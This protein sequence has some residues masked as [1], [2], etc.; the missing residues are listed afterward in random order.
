VRGWRRRVAWIVVAVA[1]LVVAARA[2]LDPLAAWRTRRILA[3]LDGMRSTF[4]RVEVSVGDLGYTIHD[5]RIEKL[6]AGGARTPFFEV[7]R[8]HFGLDWNELLHRH[9]VASVDLLRP[10]LN[11]VQAGKTRKPSETK[12]RIEGQQIEET[13]KIGRKLESLA[14]FLL[15]RL[16][17]REGEVRWIDAREPERPQLGLHGLE[18][19]IENFATRPAL[20]KGEPTVLAARATLQR[21]GRVSLFATLDPLAK[22]LTFAGQ[23]RLEG[24]R[25]VELRELMAAK[26]DIAPERGTM[27]M[28][29]RFRAVDGK[30]S[31]GL[32][33]FVKGAS[34]EPA[35][36]GVVP[37]LKSWLAD[38][39]LHIFSDDVPGRNAL[40][41]TIPLE[42]RVDHP[43]AQGIPTILGI[44]RNAFVR[45]LSDSM[46]GLPP[47]KAKQPQGALEQARHALKPKR[48]EP[49][50]QPEGDRK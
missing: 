47:P 23:A 31:G 37:R 24:L 30:L 46:T 45:G 27:D 50:A 10:K 4:S 9:V 1:V 40:A 29:L 38:E 41:T 36:P 17:V 25:L 7:E 16:Q 21:T 14:P 15:D 42:G 43:S 11:L 19:T 48:G 34:T 20:A 26:S 44:L 8:A 35:K 49:R 5:L 6:S 2:A 28:S 33:P 39:S 18:G 32:R 3:G 13:P 12:G 22:K